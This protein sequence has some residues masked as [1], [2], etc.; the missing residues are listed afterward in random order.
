MFVAV[1]RWPCKT[2]DVYQDI[3]PYVSLPHI[4]KVVGFLKL[5]LDT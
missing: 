2:V 4:F 3:I 5:T 1:P